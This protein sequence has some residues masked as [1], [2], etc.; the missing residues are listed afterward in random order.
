[1]AATE[2]TRLLARILTRGVKLP[3]IARAVETSNKASM[4]GL[5]V[6]IVLEKFEALLMSGLWL[7]PP[8]NPHIEEVELP[9]PVVVIPHQGNR[10]LMRARMPAITPRKFT[11][12]S[13]VVKE[14]LRLQLRPQLIVW[15]LSVFDRN[16]RLQL[17]WFSSG[18]LVSFL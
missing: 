8:K 14:S 18:S 16:V 6:V 17:A 5:Y 1:M 2:V 13:V 3:A 7:G 9:K 15:I 12:G 11:R 4:M 10:M